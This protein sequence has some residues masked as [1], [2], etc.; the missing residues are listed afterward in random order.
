MRCIMSRSFCVGNY[1]GG[2]LYSTDPIKQWGLETDSALV[3]AGTAFRSVM[4][5]FLLLPPLLY[6]LSRRG[7]YFVDFLI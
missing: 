4:N 1:L 2:L 3:S 5:K 6:L 7:G